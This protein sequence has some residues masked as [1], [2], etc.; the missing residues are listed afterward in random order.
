MNMSKKTCSWLFDPEGLHKEECDDT[1][2]TDADWD[3]NVPGSPSKLD[4][5]PRETDGQRCCTCD[6]DKIAA[7]SH[8]K[9]QSDFQVLSGL[10]NLHPVNP[11]DLL[12]E[13]GT[14]GANS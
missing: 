8:D 1:H 7:L 9:H 4:A 5:T 3:E 6:D 14:R 13:A 12:L 10:D 11:D 2:C